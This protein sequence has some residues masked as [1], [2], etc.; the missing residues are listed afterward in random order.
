MDLTCTGVGEDAPIFDAGDLGCADGLAAEFR[1]RIAQVEPGGRLVTV[2]RDAAA[3]SD[4][5]PLAR[6]LGHRVSDVRRLGSGRVAVTV[7]RGR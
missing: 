4:L 5:P 3:I 1:R 2:V 7:Q 6:L